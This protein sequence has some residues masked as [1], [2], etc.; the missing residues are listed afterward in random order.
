MSGTISLAAC[1]AIGNSGL[2]FRIQYT[3]PVSGKNAQYL[4][5]IRTGS[6]VTSVQYNDG[7]GNKQTASQWQSSKFPKLTSNNN[8]QAEMA[9]IPGSV[10]NAAS[11]QQKFLRGAGKLRTQWVV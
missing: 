9:A 6:E 2:C 3:D 1:T 5:P 8:Q 10:D 7:R 4:E 11:F